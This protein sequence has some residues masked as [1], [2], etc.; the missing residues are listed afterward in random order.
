MT[1]SKGTHACWTQNTFA[2]VFTDFI[3]RFCSVFDIVSCI[4]FCSLLACYCSYFV[5]FISNDW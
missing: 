2:P 4:F 3:I 1:R 5:I